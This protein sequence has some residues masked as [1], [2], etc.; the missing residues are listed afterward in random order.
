MKAALFH[1]KGDVRI[2]DIPKPEPRN[3]E[4]LIEVDW[5]GICGTDLHEYILGPIVVPRKEKP[6]IITGEHLPVVL[7]H[8]FAGS[9]V[10]TASNSD[11]KLGEKVMVD[12]RINCQSCYPCQTNIEQLCHSWGFV[13]LSGHGGGFSE[14]V[15]VSP[16]MCYRLPDDVN[17]DEA[18]LIE[19]L[20]VG[21]HALPVSGIEDFSNLTVLVV[22][23]GPIGVSV[24]WNLR[25]VGV[26]STI[27]SEPTKLR[28]AQTRDLADKVLSPIDVNIGDECRRLTDGVGVD[29]VFDCAGIPAG[30]RA[31]M[32][33]LRPRGIYVNVAGWEQPFTIPTE[34]AML[35]EITIKFSMAYDNTDFKAVVDDFIAGK[36]AGAEK[37]ITSRILL[38]DL[39][40][41]GFEELINNKDQYVKI[42]ATPKEEL[43]AKASRNGEAEVAPAKRGKGGETVIE[44]EAARALKRTRAS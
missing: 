23:A 21:R 26:K 39:P 17:M 25:A 22:G 13:G 10:K 32:D 6:H 41:Q 42:V 27:V 15:A 12:P 37:M 34:Y 35:K 40:G 43:L 7:G 4:V 19:P 20:S 14:F 1:G 38:R 18:A 11:L 36:F 24:L 9:V 33:A 31:G 2:E 8:E 16:R 30:M 44:K 5:C 3:D 28:Q 29:V